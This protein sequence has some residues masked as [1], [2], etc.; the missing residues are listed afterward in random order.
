MPLGTGRKYN[1]PDYIQPFFVLSAHHSRPN[2]VL[3]ELLADSAARMLFLFFFSSFVFFDCSDK[4]L[5]C[6]KTCL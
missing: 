5:T 4:T 2:C 3:C 6:L 1:T